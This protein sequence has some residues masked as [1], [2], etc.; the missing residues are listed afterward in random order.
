MEPIAGNGTYKACNAFLSCPRSMT[1]LWA[2]LYMYDSV[3]V[4]KVSVQVVRVR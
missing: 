1:D 2:A 3:R 4:S